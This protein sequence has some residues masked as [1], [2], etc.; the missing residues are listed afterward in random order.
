[1]EVPDVVLT[2]RGND[3]VGLGDIER[4]ESVVDVLGEGFGELEGLEEVG[5]PP[6]RVCKEEA[7]FDVGLG[8]EGVD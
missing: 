2:G 6:A 5:H 7:Q 4:I 1:M 8:A 3:D